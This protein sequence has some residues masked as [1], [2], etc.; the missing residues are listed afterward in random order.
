MKA[1]DE[2]ERPEERVDDLYEGAR[3][4]IGKDATMGVGVAILMGQLL[5]AIEMV[6]DWCEDTC[7]QVR[8]IVVR[9]QF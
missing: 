6:A 8:V 2:V 9:R 4:L 1:A 5:D 3:A 7:D